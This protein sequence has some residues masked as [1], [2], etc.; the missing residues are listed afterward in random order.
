MTIGKDLIDAVVIYAGEHAHCRQDDVAVIP[1]A[2]L[3]P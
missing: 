3:S 1:L 2:L